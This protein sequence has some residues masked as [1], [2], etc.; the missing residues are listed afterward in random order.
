MP[1]VRLNIS[2]SLCFFDDALWLFKLLLC[3]NIKYSMIISLFIAILPSHLNVWLLRRLGARIGNGCYIGMSIIHSSSIEIGD[4]VYIASFNLFHRLTKLKL[5]D[6]SRVNGFNWITGAGTGAFTLGMQSAITRFHFFESSG[7]IYIGNNSIIAGRNSHFF[8]H[9]IS[10]TNLDDVRSIV[11]G[12]WCYVGSSSRFVPGSEV[13]K[14]TFVGMGSVV[15]KKFTESYV[16]IAGN[17]AGIKKRLDIADAY[18]SRPFLPHEHHPM[19]Y[20]PG[21][22][23]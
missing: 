7:S 23:D 12:P 19:G 11:I 2:P 14:G 21:A 10:S 17:P 3:L 16:L 18:F 22:Y 1:T 20:T 5:E 6:G 15:T 8:T 4:C 13:G 9:G